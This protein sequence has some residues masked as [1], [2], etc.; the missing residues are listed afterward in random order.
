MRI[1]M[2]L[3]RLL[4]LLAVLIVVPATLGGCGT[5]MSSD[6]PVR[7]QID[8][9]LGLDIQSFGGDVVVEVDERRTDVKLIVTREGRHG[10][11]RRKAAGRDVD[12]IDYQTEVINTERGKVMR[13]VTSTS[14]EQPELLRANVRILAPAID[15]VKVRTTGGDIRLE[16][17]RGELDLLT[18]DGRI[19]VQT[20]WAMTE[21]IT[22]INN[23]GP[24]DFRVRGESSGRF[25][26]ETIGGRVS[27][28]VLFGQ[29]VVDASTDADTFRAVLNNGTNPVEMRAL[30]GD[31]RIAVMA[32]PLALGGAIWP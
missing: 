7:F 2:P 24:I 15:G 9:P 28:S 8:E 1:T 22:I 29:L 18:D 21:P 4:L 10:F 13:L 6:D 14:A 27:A 5:V 25:D 32:D 26:C 19:M 11:G 23:D 16:M 12:T 30:D 3:R 17:V 31:I 20:A